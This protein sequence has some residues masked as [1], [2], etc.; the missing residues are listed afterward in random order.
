[1]AMEYGLAPTGGWGMG[2]DR[3][4]MFLTNKWN[5]KE[6]LLFPAM[7]PTEEQYRQR[8]ALVKPHA[9]VSTEQVTVNVG[10]LTV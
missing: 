7:R 2:I 8:N 6:V 10:N 4:C 9:P 5:I 3:M 1:M